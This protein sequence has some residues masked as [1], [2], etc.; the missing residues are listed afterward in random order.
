MNRAGLGER[1]AP[2]PAGFVL[3]PLSPD[4]DSALRRLWGIEPAP[5]RLGIGK[6]HAFIY[7]ANEEGRRFW[8]VL[9]FGERDELVVAS[10]ET[11]PGVPPAP[12]RDDE[13]TPA[14]G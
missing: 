12:L 9:G 11:T 14:H 8:R 7:T 1:P 6:V 2:V 13:R 3:R 5:D 10:Q 4:D